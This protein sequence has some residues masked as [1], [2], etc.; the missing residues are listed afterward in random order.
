M[1]CGPFGKE[2]HSNFSDGGNVG[3]LELLLE[4]GVD[5]RVGDEVGNAALMSDAGA[6]CRDKPIRRNRKIPHDKK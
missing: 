1:D 6:G 4:K 5:V 3:I 2:K